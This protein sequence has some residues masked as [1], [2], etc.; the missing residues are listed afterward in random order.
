MSCFWYWSFEQTWYFV[1]QLDWNSRLNITT[2]YLH[3]TLFTG[4]VVGIGPRELLNESYYDAGGEGR[5]HGPWGVYHASPSLLEMSAAA[6]QATIDTNTELLELAPAIFSPTSSQQYSV[7]FKGENVTDTPIRTIL[8]STSDGHDILIA[9][10]VD[11]ASC[12]AAITMEGLGEYV[13]VMFEKRDVTVVNSSFVDNFDA[14]DTHIY[15][16]R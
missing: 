7:S 16:L 4:G 1:L 13:Q 11:R 5:G 3:T 2:W 14:M 10:N 8:K 12:T 9:V 6:W 15:R